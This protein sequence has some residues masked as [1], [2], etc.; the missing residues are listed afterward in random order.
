MA[1]SYFSDAAHLPSF[2]ADYSSV[3]VS[4]FHLILQ[5]RLTVESISISCIIQ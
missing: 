5:M 1:G 3:P 2:N 4:S